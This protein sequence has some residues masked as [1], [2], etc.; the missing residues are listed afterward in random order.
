MGILQANDGA[1]TSTSDGNWVPG[2]WTGAFPNATNAIAG[3]V[4]LPNA[5]DPSTITVNQNI[6]LGSLV[7]NT[8][9]RLVI[10]LTTNNLIFQNTN[11][12]ATILDSG[13]LNNTIKATVP[14]EVQLNSDL[15][16]IITDAK[17][18]IF[19]SPISGTGALNFLGDLDAILILSGS[20]NYS[21]DTTIDSGV[22]SLSGGPGVTNIPG[23]ISISSLSQVQHFRD[24][25]YSPNTDMSV[26]GG[27]VDL[28]GTTQQ[29]NKL[30]LVNG[31]IFFAS[32]DTAVL[33]LLAAT[34]DTALT[35]GNNS[36]F[37]PPLVQLVH[38]GG[39]LYDNSRTG[40][41]FI[42]N[43]ATI[44]LQGQII[45]FRVP[46]NSF[47][48]TDVDVGG[49]IFQNGTLNKTGNGVVKFQG[50]VVPTFNINE[51]IVVIGDQS[52]AELVTA[53]G[54]VTI[55]PN[56]TLEG[57]QTL[58]AQAGLIN[59]GTIAP[60]DPCTGCSTVGTLTIHG[61]Y[62][63]TSSGTLSIK[64][65]NT[66]STDKLVV[67]TGTVTLGGELTFNATP[68]AV[69]TNGDQF[70]IIN[71]TNE[72]IPISGTFSTFTANLPPCLT[73]DVIYNPH[74]V[75]IEIHDC[76]CSLTPPLPPSNFVGVVKKCKFLNR[77]VCSLKAT[78]TASPSTNVAFYR[79]YKNGNI[80]QTVS[81][82]ASLTFTVDH[83]HDCSTEGYAVAAV[84]TDNVESS[85]IALKRVSH[86]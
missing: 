50:G 45:D 34:G 16:I 3:F 61:A 30:S 67:D 12:N 13:M 41:A 38:G 18:L 48:C 37:M 46:H 84:S 23:N 43:P 5:S 82:N 81:A 70:V 54:V 25:H 76:P 65:L 73:A 62:S 56:G 20:N 11:A 44:D 47:N 42:P 64:G 51:G 77:T 32:M 6:T 59:S 86:E 21:G 83:L 52:P 4:G 28:D 7:L 68:G 71:N 2:N 53:T 9:P 27:S 63:Q 58:D 60:G 79:I 29:M 85:H 36:Q 78:W 35:I 69:F 49:A 17:A 10:D 74:Q 22:L 26:S 24:D 57:F 8:T 33:K 80:V 15:D 72:S 55:S 75:I 39:I 31:G 19:S 1:W 14:G 66:S 40:T